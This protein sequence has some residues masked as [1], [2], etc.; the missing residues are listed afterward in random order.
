MGSEKKNIQSANR[1]SSL[2]AS[3]KKISLR[4]RV[5]VMKGMMVCLRVV[6]MKFT[7]VE[8]K[9]FPAQALLAPG[10]SVLVRKHV[11]AIAVAQIQYFDAR[12]N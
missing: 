2:S 4:Y 1:P 12:I 8:V 11:I 3:T 5:R 9:R 6:S 10:H 7:V